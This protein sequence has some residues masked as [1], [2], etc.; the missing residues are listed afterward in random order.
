M[1]ESFKTQFRLIP[2]AS[3]KK[4][5]EKTKIAINNSVKEREVQMKHFTE[6]QKQYEISV[7]E[8]KPN[9]TLASSELKIGQ[10]KINIQV[11]LPHLK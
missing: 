1:Q 11:T 8:I 4:L 2:I 9:P 6:S 3:T 10:K 5:P 7:K